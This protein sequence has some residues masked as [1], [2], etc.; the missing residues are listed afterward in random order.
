[1]PFD[2]RPEGPQMK[3]CTGLCCDGEIVERALDP[4]RL[5]KK[6]ATPLI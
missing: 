2:A 3:A 6:T 1:M 5:V 4:E